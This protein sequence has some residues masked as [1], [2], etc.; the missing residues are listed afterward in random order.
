[1]SAV[2]QIMMLRSP[3]PTLGPLQTANQPPAAGVETVAFHGR[4]GAYAHLAALAAC[5][6]RTPSSY[7][8]FADAVFAVSSGAVARAII[9]VENAH[10]GPVPGVLRLLVE[11][12]VAV[13]GEHL[14][15]VKHQLVALPGASLAGLRVVRSH[16]QALAQC[17][18]CIRSHQ[19]R[20]ESASDTASAAD[21]VATGGD[22]TAAAIS[23][24]EA[25]ARYGL[26]I[27][28]EDVQDA[29][30]NVTRFVILARDPVAPP[31]GVRC[32]TSLSFSLEDR[33][34]ALYRALGA[35]ALREVNVLSLAPLSTLDG[36]AGVTF[37]MDIDG[38]PSDPPIASALAELQ[39]TCSNLQL[40]GT[41]AASPGRDGHGGSDLR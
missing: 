33:S 29:P 14:L 1:M 40:R 36:G 30:H 41:Y 20:A 25:A 6:E 21:G 4:R 16:P 10:A 34:G 39:K 26:Q 22:L 31:P 28:A 37:L 2:P 27:L 15:L 9:P 24:R 23:S 11:A 17:R 19:L 12:D 13:V 8:S 35:F 18:G 7:R 5:P 32:I 38:S 3:A